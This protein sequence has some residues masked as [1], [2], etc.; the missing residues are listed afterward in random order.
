MT[1][2]KVT[3]MPLCWKEKTTTLVEVGSILKT[4]EIYTALEVSWCDNIY[5]HVIYDKDDQSFG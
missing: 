5:F 1:T 2:H 4:V 3:P